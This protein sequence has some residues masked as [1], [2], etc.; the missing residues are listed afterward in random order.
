MPV[1]M[2]ADRIGRALVRI[3]SG[4]VERNRGVENL[5]IIGVRSRGVPI[6]RRASPPR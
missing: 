4:I 6:A 5:A 3:A 1:V 2:D